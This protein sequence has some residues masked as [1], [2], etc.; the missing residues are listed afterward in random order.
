MFDIDIDSRLMNQ[1][2]TD[3]ILYK[4]ITL[5]W[6]GRQPY[7]DHVRLDYGLLWFGKSNYSSQ[8]GK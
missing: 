7:P 5:T 1:I 2:L 4:I 6:I 3:I 8:L